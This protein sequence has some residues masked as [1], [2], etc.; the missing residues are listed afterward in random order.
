MPVSFLLYS[1]LLMP[2][3][4]VISVVFWFTDALN[5]SVISVVLWLLMPYNS[6]IS[7]IF[8]L[9][10]ALY[11][12][13]FCCTL[14]LLMPYASGISVVLWFI[15]ALCLIVAFVY[16]GLLMS[17]TSFIPF[18]ILFFICS[19]VWL[20][21]CVMFGTLL[22]LFNDIVGLGYFKSYTIKWSIISLKA[23]NAL[24]VTF[25]PAIDIQYICIG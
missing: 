21:R 11:Q 14:F 22:R 25:I 23:V 5:N 3:T 17:F 6:V 13:H 9:I 8:C 15:N 12:C 2:Y 1:G 24:I 10:N 7:V 19:I 18:F 20:L 4:S 16:S